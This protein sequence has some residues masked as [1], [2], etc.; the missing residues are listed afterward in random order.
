V[1]VCVNEELHNLYS[2]PSIIRIKSRRVR[3]PGQVARMGETRILV[4][5]QKVKETTRKTKSY[6]SG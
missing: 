6:V 2:S 4:G 1:Y 3:L 5:N